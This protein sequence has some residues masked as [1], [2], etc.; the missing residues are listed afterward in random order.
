MREGPPLPRELAERLRKLRMLL[1]RMR[2]GG[3]RHDYFWP[4]ER[5]M[6]LRRLMDNASFD[7]VNKLLDKALKD[8][9]RGR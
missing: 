8:Y 3:K 2:E 4:R 7:E 1:R 6:K 5:E 9:E